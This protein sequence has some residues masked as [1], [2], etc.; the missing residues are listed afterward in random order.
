MS[1]KIQR[2]VG[3][4]LGFGLCLLL[5]APNDAISA[6]FRCDVERK[7]DTERI[8]SPSHIGRYQFTV[9]VQDRG[10]VPVIS[11]CSLSQKSQKITCDSYNAD[12]VVVDENIRVKKFYVFRSQ[13]DVQIFKDLT[14]VENNGRGSVAY[15]KCVLVAP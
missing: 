8:Y 14:F 6:D 12:K 10:D 7:F 5:F 2:Y 13:F 3:F 1:R 15:G 4:S 11:R 9:L